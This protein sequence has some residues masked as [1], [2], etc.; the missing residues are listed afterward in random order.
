MKIAVC[1]DNIQIIANIEQIITQFFN[2]QNIDFE[3]DTYLSGERL[4]DYL[5]KNTENN[6]QLYLLDIE[7][8]QINGMEVAEEIRKRDKEAFIIF[9]TSHDEFMLKAFDVSAFH[10]LVKPVDAMKLKA[11]L[12]KVIVSAERRDNVF[13]YQSS[14]KNFTIR[15]SNIQFFESDKRKVNIYASNSEYTFYGKLKEIESELPNYFIRI[16]K[17]YIINLEHVELVEGR[18]VFMSGNHE[19]LI[20]RTYTKYFEEV[21]RR[22]VIERLG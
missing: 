22:F 20:S 6:Y 14:K 16:H 10:F 12:A 19:L 8:G 1:E 15:H 13:I 11:I 4:L 18:K 21:Y 2:S 5:S 9:I 7:M 3:L 17:S